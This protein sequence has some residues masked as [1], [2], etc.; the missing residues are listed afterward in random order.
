MASKERTRRRQSRTEFLFPLVFQDCGK[1]KEDVNNKNNHNNNCSNNYSMTVPGDLP[2]ELDLPES[3]QT[4]TP[5]TIPNPILLSSSPDPSEARSDTIHVQVGPKPSTV[6]QNVV[7]QKRGGGNGMVTPER[8]RLI[9]PAPSIQFQFQK[10][11][12]ATTLPV[13]HTA[14]EAIL[15][16][17]DMLLQAST[18][19]ET[20]QEQTNLLNLLEILRDYTETGQ[21]ARKE[22]VSSAHTRRTYAEAT[23]PSGPANTKTSLLAKP[24]LATPHQGKGKQNSNNANNTLS[25]NTHNANTA[26]PTAVQRKKDTQ[27]R[28][29]VLLVDDTEATAVEAVDPLVQRNAINTALKTVSKSLPVVA[30][31]RL[32]ARKK[33]ILTTTVNFT[34][35]FLLQHAGLWKPTVQVPTMDMQKQE[36]WIQV[37]AHKVYMHDAF[38]SSRAELKAEIETFN[39]IAIQGNS[40]WLVKREKL[41]SAYLLPPH[42]RYA[43]IVFVVGSE[44]E[45]QRLLARRQL[46]IAGRTVY[47]AKYQDISATTQC[48]SCFKLGHNREMCRSRGC[49]L[50]ASPHYTKHYAGCTECK[51]TGRL[52]KHQKPCCINCQGEHI[53]TSNRCPHLSKTST[54]TSSTP[55][56]C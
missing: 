37:V 53:A 35:D 3:P 14:Q 46:S 18:S 40:R 54:S 15:I 7:P 43:S 13:V 2:M 8:Q 26:R 51:V 1:E 22:L 6:S 24:A 44:E 48:Q 45:R 39:D 21:V 17:R 28:E 38:V 41:D 25:A 20:N 9:R 49:K 23:R 10:R 36:E 50:C 12:A 42:Q 19:A 32:I 33:I 47:L 4:P 55:L 27:S 16:A 30:N 31:V 56:P 5:T 29:L 52:C 11:K 34:P